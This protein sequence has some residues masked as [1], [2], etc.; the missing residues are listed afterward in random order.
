MGY[1]INHSNDVFQMLNLE[2]KKII[3][4]RDVIWLG[5]N[6]KIWSNTG[7]QNEKDDVDDDPNDLIPMHKQRNQVN[8][9]IQPELNERTKKKLHCQLK[10]L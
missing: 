9:N 6:F 4:S 1:S 3:N 10:H 2:R 5:K 8:D 7:S